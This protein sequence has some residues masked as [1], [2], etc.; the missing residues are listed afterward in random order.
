MRIALRDCGTGCGA[1]G[2][3]DLSPWCALFVVGGGQRTPFLDSQRQQGGQGTGLS[4]ERR[5]TR[6]L[7]RARGASGSARRCR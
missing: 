2:D 4:L 1:S 5:D 3:P 7:R 6:G